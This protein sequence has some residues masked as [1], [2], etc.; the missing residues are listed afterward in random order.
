MMTSVGS[1]RT[2]GTREKTQI[3][4]TQLTQ[5]QKPVVQATAEQIRLAQMIYDKNDRDFEDKVKQLME[6]TG[7]NQDD[8]IVALHDCNGD[9]NRAIN[10]LLEGSSDTVSAQFRVFDYNTDWPHNTNLLGQTQF[11]DAFIFCNE[12]F[13]RGRSQRTQ[14]LCFSLRFGRARGRG[15]GRFSAQGMGTFNPADYTDSSGADGFGAKQES[16]EL[17]EN[18]AADGKGTWKNSVEEWTAEDWNED[19]SETKVFTASSVPAENHVVSGQSIDLV[20]LLQNPGGPNQDLE[21]TS[22][23]A[24]Q[25]QNFGQALIFTNSQHNPQ[26]A[27]GTSNPSTVN[28]YS[29][30][31][32]SS[33][34]SSGIRE[35][36]SSKLANSTGSQILEP[37]KSPGLGQF[38][39][40]GP[41]NTTSPVSTT[42]T[43]SWDVKPSTS[44]PS[45]LSHF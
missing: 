37:L 19:L 23:D 16:W 34:L 24:S 42:P 28:T 9:V 12:D 26:M 10:L 20:T 31:S 29:A 33:V 17:G 4:A 25:Q 15:T 30:Q 22:F 43:S 1:E 21:A 6:V 7:K 44:Q 8:C 27:L 41:L 3:P 18:D 13:I 36:S 40:Q 35:L 11:H 45:I 5:P 2:R 38:A 32:L 39:S 14:S